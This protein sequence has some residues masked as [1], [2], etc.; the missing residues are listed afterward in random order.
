M[1]GQ[2]GHLFLLRVEIVDGPEGITHDLRDSGKTAGDAALGDFEQSGFGCI[3]HRQCFVALIGRPG[4]GRAADADQLPAQGFILHDPDVF[5]D[6]R[7]AGE[8]LREGSEV[9]DAADR[10]HLLAPG[11]LLRERDDIN[12]VSPV[13]Q[14]RHAGVNAPVRV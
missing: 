12:R 13:D 7:P 9:G 8:T 2:S 5:F 4:D 6:A 10:L 3:E 14:L 1:G 11:V